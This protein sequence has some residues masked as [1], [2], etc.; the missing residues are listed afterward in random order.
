MRPV[1]VLIGT[2]AAVLIASTSPSLAQGRD[3]AAVGAQGSTAGF[4]PEISYSVSPLLTLRGVGNYLA[5]DHDRTI[6]GIDYDFGVDLMSAGGFLDYHPMRNGFHVSVGALYSENE[7]NLTAFA[8]AGTIIGGTILPADS[9]LSGDLEFS[10]PIAPYVGIGYDTTFT[11]RSNW[12]FIMRAGVMYQGDPEVTLTESTGAAS[13]GDLAAEA[14][15]IEDDVDFL[16]FYPVVSVGV[17]Y[18]F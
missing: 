2:A 1:A 3:S 14:S 13:P 11:S 5:F 6:E 12:S 8:P 7:A 9:N 10:S 18:R 4:G 17:T 16:R 15:Q